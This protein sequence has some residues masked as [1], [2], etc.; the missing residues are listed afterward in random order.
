MIFLLFKKKIVYVVF[1][2]YICGNIL[3][4]YYVRLIK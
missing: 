3:K 2:L 1:F 4:G